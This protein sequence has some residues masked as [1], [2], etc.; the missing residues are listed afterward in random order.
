MLITSWCSS[1]R[2]RRLRNWHG[3]GDQH[4]RGRVEICM[5]YFPIWKRKAKQICNQIVLW[6][7][8]G[9]V[10]YGC[11]GSIVLSPPNPGS[12]GIP[13]RGWLYWSWS[14]NDQLHY[15]GEFRDILGFR[16]EIAHMWVRS[17]GAGWSISMILSISVCM[18]AYFVLHLYC[19]TMI[20]IAVSQPKSLKLASNDQC[21]R[22]WAYEPCLAEAS[23]KAG[24]RAWGGATISQWSSISRS[25]FA[26]RE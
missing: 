4:R 24:V 19:S 13:M 6:I 8:W 3:A 12:E 10:E 11:E 16:E 18:Y 14:E 7:C 15:F 17:P 23:R 20:K 22:P 25:W 2:P 21:L 26:T 9:G 5:I 1:A